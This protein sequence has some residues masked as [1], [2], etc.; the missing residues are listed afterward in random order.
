MAKTKNVQKNVSKKDNIIRYDENMIKETTRDSL[1]NEI[2]MI[3]EIIFTG[4]INEF[5]L[6]NDI[7]KVTSRIF[8]KYNFI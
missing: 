4:L 3:L 1:G 8:N 7:Q 5:L 2:H 6:I